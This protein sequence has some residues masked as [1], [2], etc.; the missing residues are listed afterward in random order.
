MLGVVDPILDSLGPLGLIE[1]LTARA[2]FVLSHLTV[3]TDVA[4]LANIAVQ[5]SLMCQFPMEK[6]TLTNKEIIETIL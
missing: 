2:L 5:F 6:T 1:I 3:V 4:F